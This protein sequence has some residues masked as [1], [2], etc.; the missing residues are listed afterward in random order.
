MSHKVEFKGEKIIEIAEEQ[1]ILEASL[2]AGIPHFHECGGNAKCS[3]CRILILDG[4]NNLSTPNKQELKLKSLLGFN[5]SIRLACQTKITGDSVVLRRIVRDQTDVSI[6]SRLIKRDETFLEVG[7]EKELALFFLDIRNFTPFMQK[8]LPFDVIH[9]I[10]RLFQIF[11]T[12]IETGHGKIIETAGDGFYAVFGTDCSL[13]NAINNAISAGR[14]LLRDLKD[15]NKA[16]A[17]VYFNHSFEVG[18]GLHAG[19]VIVGNIGLGISN[20][21]TAMGLPV[22]IA[23]RLQEATKELNNSFIVSDYA[24]SFLQSATQNPRSAN[25]SLRGLSS[26][27]KVFLLGNSYDQN[28]NPAV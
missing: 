28:K 18:I 3:T 24:Y 8:N 22:N 2:K 19:T 11:K 27:C 16:Y 26:I 4:Q 23:S 13:N 21:L 12:N 1:T 5:D 25:I 17:E 10:R 6:Y 14:Q 9:M 7:E 20:N 15:F